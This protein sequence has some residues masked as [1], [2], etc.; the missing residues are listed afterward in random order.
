MNHRHCVFANR[1]YCKHRGFRTI[2]QQTFH[3]F[4]PEILKSKLCISVFMPW[5]SAS[6]FEKNS[7]IVQLPSANLDWSLLYEKQLITLRS[8]LSYLQVSEGPRR[9]K[10]VAITIVV[11][12]EERLG[13]LIVPSDSQRDVYLLSAVRHNLYLTRPIHYR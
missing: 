12:T 13:C 11:A 9:S 6:A 5:I 1:K 2:N 4:G 7:F 3:T 8:L 10:R